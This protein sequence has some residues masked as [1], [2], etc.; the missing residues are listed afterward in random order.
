MQTTV[1]Q[2]KVWGRGG[3]IKAE[4]LLNFLFFGCLYLSSCLC[5][6]RVATLKVYFCGPCIN[7]TVFLILGYDDGKK[8]KPKKR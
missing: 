3:H 8:Q 1:E 2:G 5:L 7:T 6:D 4:G